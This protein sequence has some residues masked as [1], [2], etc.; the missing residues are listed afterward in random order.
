MSITSLIIQIYDNILKLNDN[1]VIVVFDKSKNI[2]FSLSQILKALEYNSF[3]DEMKSIKN[4][5]SDEEIS[6]YIKIIK[7]T[8]GHKLDI[9]NIQ[10]HMKMISEGGL[11]LLLNKSHKPLA[12]EL[13]HQ[14]YT[15]VLP[16]IRKTGKYNVNSNDAMKLKK[17]TR[18]LTLIST[19]KKIHSKTSNHYNNKTGNGFIYVLK[20]KTSID[21]TKTKCYKIGY[22]TDLEKR[23]ATYKTGNPDVELAHHENVSCNSKQLEDCVL[24]LNILN[25]LGFRNEIICN[26][27]LKEIKKE[28]KDCKKLII[29]HTTK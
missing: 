8:K 29:E 15:K 18:K 1:E 2:W 13:K 26:K 11:Y 10:P 21:G 17:L 23:L 4:T 12:I 5:V 16:T 6:T 14:L 28:I 9:K 3:R 27:S 7:D 24:N 19:I 20:V 22:T 25:K